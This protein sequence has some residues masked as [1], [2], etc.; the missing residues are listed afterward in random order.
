MYATDSLPF[1]MDKRRA[2]GRGDGIQKVSSIGV[3]NFE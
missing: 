2:A 1:V 3:P